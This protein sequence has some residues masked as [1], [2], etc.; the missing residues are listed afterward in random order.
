MVRAAASIPRAY[1]TLVR[2]I[3]VLSLRLP[4][5]LH[6]PMLLVQDE[7]AEEAPASH[8]GLAQSLEAE[9]HRTASPVNISCEI[10]SETGGL[11]LLNLITGSIT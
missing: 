6:L 8:Q 10:T 3:D 4:W 1:S 7:H 9:N 5:R 2:W 11:Y